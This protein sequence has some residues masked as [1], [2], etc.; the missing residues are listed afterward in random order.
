MI[1]QSLTW[2]ILALGVVQEVV[3]GHH[4]RL[5]RR[6]RGDGHV[7]G[8]L[9]EGQQGGAAVPRALREHEQPDLRR[10]GEGP[11]R[12]GL[13]REVPS[14][15][16]KGAGVGNEDCNPHALYSRSFQ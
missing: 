3:P 8:A 5:D 15:I 16:P 9:L 11:V 1:T 2:V 7:K 13:A 6:L 14:V 12:L 4:D 10:S